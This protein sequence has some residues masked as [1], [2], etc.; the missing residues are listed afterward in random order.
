LRAHFNRLWVSISRL[1][2]KVPALWLETK[3]T[4]RQER[5]NRGDEF[6]QSISP[7]DDCAI[8]AFGKLLDGAL[9]PL[10]HTL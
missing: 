9:V 6:R 3:I 7:I 5:L 10:E 2:Q 4:F 1:K 8:V